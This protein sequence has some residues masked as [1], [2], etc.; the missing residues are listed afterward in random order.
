MRGVTITERE[1]VRPEEKRPLT[2]ADKTEVLRRWEA[3]SYQI[4]H[5]LLQQE[6]AA[7]AAAAGALLELFG[8]DPFFALPAAVQEAQV[9][10]IT[11]KHALLVRKQE[12]AGRD[13][14]IR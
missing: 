3:F 6:P 11:M 14:K 4:A 1:Q 12:A 7:E 5:Y 13:A 9:R 2:S 8:S 10:K